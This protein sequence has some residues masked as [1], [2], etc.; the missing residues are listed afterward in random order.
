MT[1]SPATLVMDERDTRADPLHAKGIG[2]L[3]SSGAGAAIARAVYNA[4]GVRI[5]DYAQTR[6]KIISHLPPP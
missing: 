5:R 4:C 3:G 6:A 2:E 1:D